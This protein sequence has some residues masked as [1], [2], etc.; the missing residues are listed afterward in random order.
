ML[1]QFVFI[2]ARAEPK[3]LEKCLRLMATNVMFGV[4]KCLFYGKT[5][6]NEFQGVI[7]PKNHPKLPWNPRQV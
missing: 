2:F 5:I 3:R 1:T 7:S 4:I 6:L